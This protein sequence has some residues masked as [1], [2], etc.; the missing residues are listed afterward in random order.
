MN[1]IDLFSLFS[2]AE[3][4]WRHLNGSQLPL[5]ARSACL[6]T[7]ASL[8]VI[9]ML[10]LLMSQTHALIS[11]PSGNSAPF[12]TFNRLRACGRGYLEDLKE[13]SKLCLTLSQS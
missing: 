5:T 4:L 9:G 3:Q 13:C 12:K 6:S 2:G 11:P 10:R 7:L 1:G 8:A